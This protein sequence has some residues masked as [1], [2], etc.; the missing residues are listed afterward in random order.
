[1]S[2]SLCGKRGKA[3]HTL[4]L[5]DMR[6]LGA[7]IGLLRFGLVDKEERMRVG[8]IAVVSAGLLA[9]VVSGAAQASI[10]QTRI[11]NDSNG[12]YVRVDGGTDATIASCGR[13]RLPQNEPTIAVDPH[14][15]DVVVAGANDSCAAWAG[16]Y[17]STD[18]GL[19]WQDSLVPGYPADD[20]DAGKASPTQGFCSRAG[21]PTQ[22]FDRSGR[23]FYG[24]IC[25]NSSKPQNGS[26]YVATYDQDG[27]H[28]LRTVQ[29]AAGTPS[30]K[31]ET[32]GLFQDKLNLAV[33]QT[34][35][36]RSGFVY[37]AWS[38]YS[39]KALNNALLF[40]RSTDHGASFSSPIKL[41]TGPGSAN[42][43][44]VAVG[45]DGAVY[46]TYR[47]Y[48][49]QGPTTDSIWLVKSTDG[50]QTFGP[51]S[52]VAA[53]TPF[54][55]TQFTGGLG[56]DVNACG[57][58]AS[59]CR[60]GF[61]FSRFESISAVAAD[62]TG[63][64]VVWSARLPSGQAKIFVRNSPDGLSWP[65][66]AAPLD[67]FPDGHQYYPDIASADGVI[68]V[69]FYD[70]RADPSYSPDLPPGNTAHGVNSGFVSIFAQVVGVVDTYV[71]TSTDGGVHW[72]ETK[73]SNVASNF[74][75]E[76]YFDPPF[77]GDYIYV[78]A[79]PGA[80]NI[81]WTDSRD[82]SYCL[83]C[84]SDYFDVNVP[85]QNIYGARVG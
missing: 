7:R 84:D 53:I 58:G 10:V 21:D 62:A 60:S 77:W 11:T 5:Q 4:T 74:D 15:T 13:A 45:P 81:A 65:T 54:D 75:W 69:V 20:S 31:S 71:A 25:F 24:F 70:S 63:V 30:S 12:A 33:D 19:T 61:T 29:V 47:L 32:T 37:V 44:D 38:R 27:S 35:G 52:L 28:Y 80:V 17:R 3:Q 23:L 40:S 67:T 26:I 2:S 78:S 6:T 85:D 8:L 56:P 83:P 72:A 43:A 64:H 59:A 14:S 57:D 41:D 42:D 1:M 68:T 55:S 82:L 50:G 34:T 22:F 49:L 51:P 79:V 76:G 36:S 73:V 39:G 9:L 46:V 18:G 66:P 48:N 16:Y